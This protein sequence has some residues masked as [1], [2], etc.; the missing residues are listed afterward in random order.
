MQTYSLVGL[1]AQQSSTSPHE[2][3]L[4]GYIAPRVLSNSWTLFMLPY[5]HISIHA[6]NYYR[7]V[8]ALLLSPMHCHHANAAQF[9]S[10]PTEWFGTVRCATCL[11]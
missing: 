11:I 7:E 4:L 9:A 1:S 6:L 3:I 10:V 5:V 8:R 2:P